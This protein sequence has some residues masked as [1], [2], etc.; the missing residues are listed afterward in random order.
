[1]NEVSLSQK[2]SD[3]ALTSMSV[4]GHGQFAAVGDADGVVTLLQLCDGLF[5]PAPNEKNLIGLMLE[6]E[7][8]RERN[9]EQIKK[10][11][12]VGK[13]EKDGGARAS[14]SIDQNEYQA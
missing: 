10:Q 3:S 5:T 6:R 4:Q 2:V 11:A 13:K 9:L 12:G 8:K 14:I 1:M 7:T